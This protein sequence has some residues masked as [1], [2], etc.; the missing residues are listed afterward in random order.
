MADW[1]H[2]NIIEPEKLPLLLCFAAFVVT[3]LTTRGITRLIRAGEGPFK[4]DVSSSGVHIHHAVPGLVL[5]TVGSFTSIATTHSPWREL[6]AIA[7]GIGT[8]LVLDEFALILRL[9]DV[10][11]TDEGRLSVEMVS[12]AIACMGFVIIGVTPAGVDKVGE[13]ELGIR[14]SAVVLVVLNLI[15]L[16]ICVVKGKYRLALFG[17]FVPLLAYA[18]AVRLAR[19]HSLWA[20]HRYTDRPELM[21]K[22]TKRAARFDAR[23]DPVADKVSDFVAGKPSEPVPAATSA[24]PA[25][26]PQLPEAGQ[27]GAVATGQ[28]DSHA[29]GSGHGGDT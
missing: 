2:R 9:Q 6:A 25:P 11:W 20:E 3:F 8:S 18:G 5:L 10:Y 7:I 28:H 17:I 19:P 26:E 16:I 27:A 15:C 12:L 1:W 22:A 21:D 13:A 14:T 23:V 29:G 24:S 4:N